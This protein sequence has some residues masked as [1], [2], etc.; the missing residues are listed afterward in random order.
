VAGA[1]TFLRH[2]MM[3]KIRVLHAMTVVLYFHEDFHYGF[4]FVHN[5]LCLYHLMYIDLDVLK[6]SWNVPPRKGSQR[7]N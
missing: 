3:E 4:L 5:H 6:Q 2:C 1:P 7:R